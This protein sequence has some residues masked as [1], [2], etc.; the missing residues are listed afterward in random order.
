MKDDDFKDFRL[1]CERNLQ[2]TVE[3]QMHYGFCYV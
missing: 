3:E 2:R 1:Q